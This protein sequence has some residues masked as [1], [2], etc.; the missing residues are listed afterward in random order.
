MIKIMERA[1]S[2]RVLI[3]RSWSLIRT[4]LAFG[5]LIFIYQGPYFRYFG[6]IDAKN[7]NSV[8]YLQA[9]VLV[10]TVGKF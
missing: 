10:Y 3:L 7:V 4:F 9:L 5:V 6:F 1:V 8:S 2:K